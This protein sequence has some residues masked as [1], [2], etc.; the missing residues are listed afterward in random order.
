MHIPPRG[1]C[2]PF[3]ANT[4]TAENARHDARHDVRDVAGIF[5]FAAREGMTMSE[6]TRQIIKW[7]NKILAGCWFGHGTQFRIRDKYGV[8]HY[9][10]ER[11]GERGVWYGQDSTT[12][13]HSQD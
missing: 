2:F 10:C 7:L 3:P 1:G 5:L 4:V 9:E 12:R 11:C 8:L 13:T 6:R